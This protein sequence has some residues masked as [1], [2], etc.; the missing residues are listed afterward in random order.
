MYHTLSS[1]AK[2]GWGCDNS[3]EC[4]PQTLPRRREN[5]DSIEDRVCNYE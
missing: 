4:L 3:A 5:L 1:P 2:V